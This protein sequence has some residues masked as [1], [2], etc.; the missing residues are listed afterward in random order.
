ML[1]WNTANQ[2]GPVLAS[3]VERGIIVHSQQNCWVGYPAK[4]ENT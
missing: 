2:I 3:H 1:S 4:A